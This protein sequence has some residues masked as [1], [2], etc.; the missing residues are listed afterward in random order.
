M[1]K[2]R[3]FERLS[4][5][6]DPALIDG[7]SA[8][9]QLRDSIVQ[10]LQRLLNT[11][12]GSVPIDAEYGMP[13]MSNI[14]GSFAFGTTEFLSESLLKQVLRYEP[15]L[16]DPQIEVEKE[17]RDVITLRFGLTGYVT[18]GRP[19]GPRDL[20]SMTIRIN[21]TGQIFVEARHDL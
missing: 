14:A 15:R 11:R 4:V 8:D 16:L 17:T 19:D 1:H 7:V 21:S 13:D 9:R 5:L 2:I 3:L 12:S 18:Y 10:H 20:L 6:E